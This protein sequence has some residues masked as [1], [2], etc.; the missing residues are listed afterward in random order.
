MISDPQ[1]LL[2]DEATSA[3]DNQSEA[4]VQEA[5]DNVAHGRTIIIVAHR[6]STIK[7]ADQ[8][9]AFSEGVI[10]ERGTHQELMQRQGIYYQLVVS[11][12]YGFTEDNTVV[13]LYHTI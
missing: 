7:K 4:Q 6:L 1:I 5:I 9:L 10:G 12:T 3:L 13:S 2:L 11:Q 8:I